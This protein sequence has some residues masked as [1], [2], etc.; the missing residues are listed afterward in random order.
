MVR[1]RRRVI[2][3]TGM[4]SAVGWLMVGAS[5]VLLIV[6]WWSVVLCTRHLY[7]ELDGGQMVL[8]WTGRHKQSPEW[9]QRERLFAEWVVLWS[10]EDVVVA[11][12]RT[13]M[14]SRV[15]WNCAFVRGI[16]SWWLELP[17]AAIA[18]AGVVLV[19][20]A[21]AG[22]RW[23]LRVRPGICVNCGYDLRGSPERCPEC[24]TP[25]P[26][27]ESAGEPGEMTT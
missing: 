17:I 9:L 2:W 3:A 24:G 18:T 5:V 16:G 11:E 19:G 23:L 27:V 6:S 7:C 26:S 20:I 8:Q 25:A 10:S 4:C 1:A 21:W 13:T 14:H 15:Y 22:R 12:A